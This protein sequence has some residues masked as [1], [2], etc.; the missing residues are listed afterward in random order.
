LRAL[1]LI[2][3]LILAVGSVFGRDEHDVTRRSRRRTSEIGVLRVLASAASMCSRV[4]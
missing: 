2:V 1:G 3:A 4:S